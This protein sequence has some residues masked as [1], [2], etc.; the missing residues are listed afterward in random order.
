METPLKQ[1]LVIKQS[2][3][4]LD[5]L[6][7]FI[8]QK[9]IKKNKHKCSS[10]VISSFTADHPKNQHLLPSWLKALYLN[11]VSVFRPSSGQKCYI[12]CVTS[13]L[14]KGTPVQLSDH[15]CVCFIRGWDVRDREGN[16]EVDKLTPNWTCTTMYIVY[17]E[18]KKKKER[19]INKYS[20]Y[21]FTAEAQTRGVTHPNQQVGP[22]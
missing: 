15:R 10:G 18:K 7:G 9:Q 6:Q 20:Y 11:D 8:I 4:V 19:K 5:L 13:R 14:K 12:C 21:Y 16:L 2:C 17:M 1:Q 3:E 22:K